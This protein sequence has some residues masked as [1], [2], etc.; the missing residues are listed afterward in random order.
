[1]AGAV[2]AVVTV[3]IVALAGADTGSARQ[4]V[5]AAAAGSDPGQCPLHDETAT[6]PD[7]MGQWMASA[8]H[9]DWVASTDRVERHSQM[10]GVEGP[11]H[12]DMMGGTGRGMR[13][14]PGTGSELMMG[15]DSMMGSGMGG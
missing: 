15:R 6:S 10:H 9:Q 5:V 14:S 4:P 8:T 13:M 2:I 3:P 7:E 12:G 11:M 1:M